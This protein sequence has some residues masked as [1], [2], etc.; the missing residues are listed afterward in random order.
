MSTPL[1]VDIDASAPTKP[2][3]STKVAIY[4]GLLVL[5]SVALAIVAARCDP[6]RGAILG[7][8]GGF[9]I[10]LTLFAVSEMLVLH[11]H[12]GKSGYT[13]SVTEAV[14]VV[15]L[16]HSSSVSALFAQVIG[17]AFV[18]AVHR[19]QKAMK[20]LF[21]SA[22]FAVESQ[23][24]FL[25]FNGVGRGAT[26]W[27]LSGFRSW[28]AAY[29][30]VLLFS[31]IG[32]ALVFVVIFLA[33]SEFSLRALASNLRLAFATSITAASI[34]ITGATLMYA[35]APA[36]LLLA[37]PILGVFWI[38]RTYLS[39]RKRTGELEFL[40]E[41]S[42]VLMGSGEADRALPDVLEAA[43]AEF[44]VQRLELEYLNHGQ[45][46]TIV[47]EYLQAPIR[48]EPNPVS[49]LDSSPNK[50][51]LLNRGTT[52][53]RSQEKLLAS[54]SATSAVIAPLVFEGQ[55]EGVLFLGNPLA[56]HDRFDAEDVRMA[57]MLAHHVAAAMQT[58][59]LEQ[60]VA[61]LR[62]MESDLLFELQH[63]PLTGLF[64]RSAFTRRVRET[65]GRVSDGRLAALCFVDLDD[66]KTVND[67]RGHATGDMLLRIVGQ[68]L[69]S[70]MRSH[71]IASRLGGDEFAVLFHPLNGRDEAAS[72][73]SR[74][75]ECL[76]EPIDTDD[77]EPLYPSVSIGIAMVSPNDDVQ[78]IFSRAD[79][80]MYR[81][82]ALGKGRV[83]FD[84]QGLD[85]SAQR[86]LE[87]GRDLERAIGARELQLS[88]QAVH[89][90]STNAVTGYASILQWD[91][92]TH[93]VLFPEAFAGPSMRGQVQRLLRQRALSGI[94]EAF[95]KVD[96]DLWLSMSLTA[97][98]LLDGTLVDDLLATCSQSGISPNRI[99][100]EVDQ[101]S[102]T[103][104]IEA[105]SRRIDD[106]RNAGFGIVLA[107]LGLDHT[108]VGWIERLRP[109]C[110][111]LA[112]EVLRERTVRP[113]VVPF[114]RSIVE[115]G[116][117]LGFDV[118][119]DGVDQSDDA[120]SVGVLG[121]RYGQGV[122]LSARQTV[123]DLDVTPVNIR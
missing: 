22:M 96:S 117:D 57:E 93:G 74:L 94:V 70:S 123:A 56:H 16:F 23:I 64:N 88:F 95:A 53:S 68:R 63:E 80:A 109:V 84:G 40:Q 20:I 86:E 13:F 60:S 44:C 76:R 98:Q 31:V 100:V 42:Q 39:E 32:V 99:R 92:P 38:N 49:L 83:E 89:T 121:C 110:V 4:T 112:P 37:V 113:A 52:T 54:R 6:P 14:L 120:V 105:L 30:S 41:S 82:K 67:T 7:G 81:A 33:D 47:A 5:V 122:F 8:I 50:A 87:L 9:A 79:S 25:V 34:G 10:L 91:H 26:V 19:K 97:P 71:D 102:F 15:A 85:D 78:T 36:A 75:L 90:L 24:A 61:E 1:S 107:N 108:T 51:A 55:M 77:G 65:V 3:T 58:G 106:V 46:T 21:N 12:I 59:R 43:R 114:I 73:A 119:A 118:V 28:L 111:K 35:A 11:L 45:R 2:R 104:S 18:L 66:F 72:A 101:R 116:R 62:G 115:L 29:V 48:T 27:P 17:G 69:Q 103:R